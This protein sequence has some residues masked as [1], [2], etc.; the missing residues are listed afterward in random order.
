MGC[1]GAKDPSTPIRPTPWLDGW[2]AA[3]DL[4][5]RCPRWWFG[6]EDRRERVRST[7]DRGPQESGR[8]IGCLG[9]KDPSTPIRPT[10]W[11][12]GWGA[13]RD[14]EATAGPILIHEVHS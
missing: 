8:Q 9:A 12:D 2:G 5:S 6:D 3:R 13:A 7:R 4:V 10:P 11:L 1:L 14:L